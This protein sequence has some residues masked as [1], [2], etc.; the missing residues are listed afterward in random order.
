MA[1]KSNKF[2]RKKLIL[3]SVIP[4]IVVLIS[5]AA[6][7]EVGL[8]I[9]FRNIERITGIAGWKEV[10][11][12][13]YTYYG[14]IYHPTRGW[15]NRPGYHS[16]A[17]RPNKVVIN[18]QGLRSHREFPLQPAFG[19]RRIAIVGDSFTFGDEVNDDQTLP[20]YLERFLNAT[21]VLNFGVSGYGVDQM[22]LRLEEDVFRY[23]PTHVMFV[24]AIPSDLARA[25]V[26]EYNHPKPAFSVNNGQLLVSNSPVPVRLSQSAIFRHSFLAAWFLGRPKE[27]NYDFSEN[28]VLAV[29]QALLARAKRACQQK[30]IPLIV[31][32][33]IGPTFARGLNDAE[34]NSPEAEYHKKVRRMMEAEGLTIAS[35][36]S[37]LRE[38]IKGKKEQELRSQ[39]SP[40]IMHWAGRGNC[41]LAGNIASDLMSLDLAWRISDS[42]P[43]CDPVLPSAAGK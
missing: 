10:V 5:F 34:E 2:S 4:S 36:Y 20:Y 37:F 28:H 11:N 15:T 23:N 19:V 38:M 17:S 39:V 25:I 41:L 22:V 21:E 40:T 3:F 35:Q 16:D 9:K 31:V 7:S 6:I 13:V 29:S 30:G 14:D 42:P 32:P 27:S 8:R 1:N 43:H 18:S 12:G 24:I 33:I 26:S